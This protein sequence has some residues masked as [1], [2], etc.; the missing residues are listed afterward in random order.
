VVQCCWGGGLSRPG[1]VC[2]HSQI[3]IIRGHRVVNGDVVTIRI[4]HVMCVVINVMI[5]KVRLMN[6]NLTSIRVPTRATTSGTTRVR[7][8]TATRP[9]TGTVITK[10]DFLS[11]IREGVP[12]ALGLAV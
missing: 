1:T 7:P 4:I 2:G 11:R 8:V 12:N 10:D 3:L 9:I 5:I 6:V